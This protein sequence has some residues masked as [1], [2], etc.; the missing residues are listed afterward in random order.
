MTLSVLLAALLADYFRPLQ[1]PSVAD[2][3]LQGRADWMLRHFDAGTDRY[4]WLAMTLGIF[5]PA[6]AGG[7]IMALVKVASVPMAW[8]LS[9]LVLYFSIGFRHLALDAMD[10]VGALTV[11]DLERARRFEGGW[12][13]EVTSDMNAEALVD[14]GMRTVF[15]QALRRL[16][17]VIFWY[18]LLGVTGALLYALTQFFVRHWRDEALFHARSSQ[19]LGLM[20][21]LPARGMALSFA[22][23]GQ[24]D[25]ALA[26]WRSAVRS[27]GDTGR[28]AELSGAGALGADWD[29]TPEAG[30]SGPDR[31]GTGQRGVEYL[32]GA[33]NLVWRALLLWLALL[34]LLWLADL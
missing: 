16:F 8:A 3:W 21:W 5:L 31:A 2:H 27:T 12:C 24:F 20:E 4:V 17:S 28:I 26:G 15:R 1:R 18:V 10:A 32:E 9:A 19:V 25:K 11:G 33:V 23:V 14:C 34:G 30:A 6:L 29:T 7:L 13:R 22:V